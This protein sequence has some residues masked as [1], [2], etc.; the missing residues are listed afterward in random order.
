MGQFIGIVT[1]AKCR[2]T[3]FVVAQIRQVGVVHLHVVATCG[4]QAS[5][6]VAISFGNV[7]V[8]RWLQL[9]VGCAADACTPAAKVQH[10][11]RGNGDF[12][13]MART[14]LRLK[15]FKVGQL[16]LLGMCDFVHNVNRWR[17]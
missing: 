2:R 1:T 9:G 14:D 12:G 7:F 4:A 10:G 11:G 17:R 16:N 3:H 6:L 8:E 13:R 5:Q 15:V